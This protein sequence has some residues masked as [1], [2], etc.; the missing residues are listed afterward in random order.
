MIGGLIFGAVRR[1]VPV[2]RILLV[3]G[4]LGTGYAT[5]LYFRLIADVGPGTAAAVD[6]LV[7]V[8]AVIFGV[9]LL[10]EPVT[11][12]LVAGGLTVLAGVAVVQ[13]RGRSRQS[14]HGS[15]RHQVEKPREQEL[16]QIG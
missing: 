3:L 6:Y 8:F 4:L 10:S 12:N 16:N 1:P 11:W 13:S 2:Y 7:P 14:G 9:T 15:R 5:I